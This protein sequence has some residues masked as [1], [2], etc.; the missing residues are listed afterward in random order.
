MPCGVLFVP[1]REIRMLRL[2][3]DAYFSAA[4]SCGEGLGTAWGQSN[5]LS[6]GAVHSPTAE[7]GVQKIFPDQRHC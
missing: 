7:V 2:W 5:F 1:G 4:H 3:A 6:P